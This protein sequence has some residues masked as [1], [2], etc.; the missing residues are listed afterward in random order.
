MNDTRVI[1]LL[2]VEDTPAYAYLVRKAFSYRQ[3]LTRWE[4]TIAEDGEQAV[5]LL[6]GDE[7]QNM[8]FQR[9]SYSTGSC[10]N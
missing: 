9:S 7:K 3:N 6:L 1:R 2:V 8:P 10:R 5:S 4:L